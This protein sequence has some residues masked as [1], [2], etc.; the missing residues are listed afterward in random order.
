[1]S[2]A[3]ISDLTNAYRTNNLLDLVTDGSSPR[4]STLAGNTVAQAML[5]QASGMVNAAALMGQRYSVADLVGLTGVD[6][7][8]LTMIT[9]HLAYGLLLKRI[10]KGES[11]PAEYGEAKDLLERLRTG[12]QVFDV[13]T[14]VDAGVNVSGYPSFGTYTTV[15][16][17]RDAASRAYPVR[18]QQNISRF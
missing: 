13:V 6:Q 5:D 2:Y 4:P 16:L 9:V 15:N 8:F 3:T 12:E 14:A 7:A 11:L 18:R 1:M 17:L 10:G